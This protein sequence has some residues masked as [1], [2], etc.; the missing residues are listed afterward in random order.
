MPDRTEILPENFSTQL[1]DLFS[2]RWFL[3]SA[4]DFSAGKFNFMTVS[5]GYLGVMWGKPSAIAVVRPQRY[6][7]EFLKNCDSFTLSA[8]PEQYRDALN[9]CGSKS[10]KD[11]DK[12]AATGLTPVASETVSAPAFKEAE[13]VFECRQ[14]Y[15]DALRKENFLDA[16]IPPK[17]YPEN[18]YHIVFIGEISRITGT[19]DYTK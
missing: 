13:L 1:F 3:L 6:T 17:F 16:L 18:D 7:M 9:L 15:K 5:W 4:G 8:F 2:K 12:V 11:I 14:L 10:G 19:G